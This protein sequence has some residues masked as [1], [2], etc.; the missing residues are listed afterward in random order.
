MKKSNILEVGKFE[1]TGCSAC[2]LIC[3][4]KCISFTENTKGFLQPI[5][6][7][8]KC[9]HC[10][11]CQTVCYK[12]FDT[13]L[14]KHDSYAESEIYGVINN[15]VKQLSEVSTLGIATV[16]ADTYFRQN[17][18]VVGV[19]FDPITNNCYHKIAKSLEDIKSFTGSKYLQSYN[20]DAF[21]DA[22]NT[23]KETVVFGTPCQIYGLQQVIKKKKNEDRF[24]LVDLCCAGVPSKN[25]WLS[26]KKHLEK[27]FSIESDKIKDVKFRD[28]TQGWHKFSMKV[29]TSS[30]SYRQNVFNDT[31]FHFFVK[32]YCQN[33]SCYNCIFRHKHIVSDIRLGDFWGKKYQVFDDGVELVLLNTKKGKE[34]WNEIKHLFRYEVC[35]S[36]DVYQSQKFDEIEIPQCY[37]N[38][39]TSLANGEE[40]DE[41]LMKINNGTYSFQN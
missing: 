25:L 37:D 39:I 7:L 20:Y 32:K 6:D 16:I 1:C 41:I 12:Y 11:L 24:L 19:D 40:L 2:G 23:D 28:K 14:I 18:N 3:P 21:K 34:A 36:E 29:T 30:K 31:F 13:S 35:C 26:Y 17:K 4:N 9:L 5:V 22:L 38:I 27:Y 15:Y 33:K 8:D 10:G